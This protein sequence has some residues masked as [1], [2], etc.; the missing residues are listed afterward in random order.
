MPFTQEQIQMHIDVLLPR[1]I[2]AIL[3]HQ[4]GELLT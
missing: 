1:C 2:A 3:D 4:A